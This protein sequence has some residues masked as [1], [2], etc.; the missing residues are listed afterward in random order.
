MARKRGIIATAQNAITGAARTGIRGARSMADSAVDTAAGAANT[1]A[2]AV[3]GTALTAVRGARRLVGP[4]KKRR[5]PKRRAAG[6][7]TKKVRSAPK[8]KVAARKTRKV[9]RKKK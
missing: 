1:A 5:S 9:A 7:R 8:R 4:A 3:T 2:K 6:R